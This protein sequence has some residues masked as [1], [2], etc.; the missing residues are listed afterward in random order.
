MLLPGPNGI[1]RM[2]VQLPPSSTLNALLRRRG[3]HLR[4]VTDSVT[5]PVP[6][7][8]RPFG[9]VRHRRPPLRRPGVRG[10]RLRRD[11]KLAVKSGPRA[12]TR[13]PRVTVINATSMPPHINMAWTSWI[14]RSRHC[15]VALWWSWG[16]PRSVRSRRT[17]PKHAMPGQRRFS[18]GYTDG[19]GV[20]V[21]DLVFSV[22]FR[23]VRPFPDPTDERFSAKAFVVSPVRP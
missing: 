18:L 8:R 10:R 22:L 6:L 7:A 9:G 5:E 16:N 11:T 19:L 2:A 15:S 13:G 17:R 1:G 4:A 23:S 21:V 12:Q 3:R 20:S 14:R